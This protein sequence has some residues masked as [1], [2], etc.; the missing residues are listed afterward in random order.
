M[1]LMVQNKKTQHAAEFFVLWFFVGNAEAQIVIKING[2]MA[3]RFY[4]R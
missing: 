1:F 4:L 3:Q 2:L